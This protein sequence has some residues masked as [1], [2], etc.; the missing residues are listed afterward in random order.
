MS[1]HHDRKPNKQ[2]DANRAKAPSGQEL[3]GTEYSSLKTALETLQ[4]NQGQD[5]TQTKIG[6]W[7]SGIAI[8][9]SLA[10]ASGTIWQACEAYRTRTDVAEEQLRAR[11]AIKT[12]KL[13]T[14]VTVPGLAP[15]IY[16]A[17]ENTGHS[18]AKELTATG[19]CQFLPRMP[20]GPMPSDLD[21]IGRDAANPGLIGGP[22]KATANTQYLE[23]GT[24]S[25]MTLGRRL[26]LTATADQIEQV[27]SGR[28]RLYVFVRI[29]YTSRDRPHVLEFCGFALNNST[30]LNAC[31]RWNDSR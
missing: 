27:K 21:S 24:G 7:L 18:A 28:L 8:A 4:T 14:P 25:I 9:V 11:L 12:V 19:V 6:I 5:R 2:K 22:T 29:N 31:E 1:R 13:T 20:D 16:M 26:Y 23:A 30:E 10:A 17:F 15:F 3:A